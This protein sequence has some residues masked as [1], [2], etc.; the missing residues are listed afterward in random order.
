MKYSEIPYDEL[1]LNR[2]KARHFRETQYVPL[3]LSFVNPFGIG[4]L[5]RIYKP[6]REKMK[7]TCDFKTY[8]AVI[9]LFWET[10]ITKIVKENRMF[11]VKHIGNI[12]AFKQRNELFMTMMWNRDFKIIGGKLYGKKDIKKADG[13]YPSFKWEPTTG[14]RKS[15]FSKNF[16]MRTGIKMRH[17]L[18][19]EFFEGR[20]MFFE[21]FATT[22]KKLDSFNN[23]HLRFE[24][25]RL[26]LQNTYVNYRRNGM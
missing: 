13:F 2:E 14:S 1:V 4:E 20:A 19:K 10:L 8:R 12:S 11:H 23:E 26:A 18:Y 17:L 15:F 3:K 7:I 24:K 6:L 9:E 16:F 21:S 25:L 22:E 5:W